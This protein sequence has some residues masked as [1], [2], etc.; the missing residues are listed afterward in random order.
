MPQHQ[1]EASYFSPDI[2]EFI[3]LLHARQVR[4][5][6]VGGEAVIYYGHARLTGDIDFFYD[7]SPQNTAALF[8]A[9]EVF[10]GGNVPGIQRAE[11]FQDK[12]V[13][14]QFGR[15][16]NRIDLLNQIDGVNFPEAWEDHVIVCLR[17]G[18]EEI[19]LY[20]LSLAKLILNKRASGRAKDQEDLKFL[21]QL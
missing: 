12:G 21:L 1:L 15:P 11:E 2:L 6:V 13:I 18:A 8:A 19:P 14:V 5:V 17:I 16:P 9:L 10:W 7:C 3:K 4:Y 20:Y